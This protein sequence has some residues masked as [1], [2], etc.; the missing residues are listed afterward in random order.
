MDSE[1]VGVGGVVVI[2]IAESIRVIWRE[3]VLG[4]MS[5]STMRE[6]RMDGE[7]VRLG[8]SHRQVP[9]LPVR[10]LFACAHVSSRLLRMDAQLESTNTVRV[11]SRTASR[12]Q[13]LNDVDAVSDWDRSSGKTY[14][15]PQ[16]GHYSTAVSRIVGHFSPDFDSNG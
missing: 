1:R 5:N 2:S 13:A 14:A 15:D 12:I 4:Y 7:Q 16:A 11:T 3:K 9:Q 10:P 6:V 8:P